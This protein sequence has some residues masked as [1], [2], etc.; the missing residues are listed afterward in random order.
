[1]GFLDGLR[2][3]F[4]TIGECRIVEELALEPR[5]LLLG[6][7][8]LHHGEELQEVSL[9]P[10]VA[11]RIAARA[12]DETALADLVDHGDL[13]RDLDGVRRRHVLEDVPIRLA[14]RSPSI[15]PRCSLRDVGGESFAARAQVRK[16]DRRSDPD[17]AGAAGDGSG[18]QER[19]GNIAAQGNTAGP[20]RIPTH[21]VRADDLVDSGGVARLL[22]FAG[23]RGAEG[24]QAN[25]HPTAV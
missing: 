23:F 9:A 24:Q 13:L 7:R 18:H 20:H 19:M 2:Q 21:L 6:P 1:M 25:V 5:E 10:P 4:R 14:R 16:V 17:P 22:R 11:D 8:L 3:N 12:V 15:N